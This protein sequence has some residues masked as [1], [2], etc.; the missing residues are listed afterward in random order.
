MLWKDFLLIT[1]TSRHS[2]LWM[3]SKVPLDVSLKENFTENWLQKT[4]EREIAFSPADINKIA[5]IK[6]TIIIILRQHSCIPVKLLLSGQQ[7]N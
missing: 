3:V 4:E 7:G 1:H 5:L 6:A 2:A